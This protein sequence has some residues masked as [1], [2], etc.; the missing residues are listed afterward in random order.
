MNIGQLIKSFEADQMKKQVPPF[1]PGDTINVSLKIKE[2]EKERV[3]AFQ[4]IVVQRSGTGIN[5]TV[6][7]RKL[8]EGVGVERIFPLHAENVTD[9]KIVKQ[10]N[11]RRSKLYYL[12]KLQGK[13][14]R[15]REKSDTGKV[16]SQTPKPA[17][18]SA[19]ATQIQQPHPVSPPSTKEDKKIEKPKKKQNKKEGKP[20]S[21]KKP[22]K[23]ETK[24][25]VKS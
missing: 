22:E 5:E 6:T 2:G 7:V 17:T 20:K 24:K 18:G 13:A 4:G 19:P 21:E 1:R 11:V 9:I 10:G 8:S 14:A 25:A 3:Q 12:R 16:V 15:I 23:K